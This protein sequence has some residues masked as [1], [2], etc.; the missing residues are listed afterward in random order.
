[1]TISFFVR[2]SFAF[3][4]VTGGEGGESAEGV[5]VGAIFSKCCMLWKTP[6]PEEAVAGGE[7]GARVG[8]RGVGAIFSKCCILWKTPRS[9]DAVD[10]IEEIS[11][12]IV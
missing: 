8:V 4:I 2:S 10:R 7:A 5:G 9:E 12:Y 11:I 6:R 1:M 3:L